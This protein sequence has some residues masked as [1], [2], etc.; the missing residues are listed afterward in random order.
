MLKL[1]NDPGDEREDGRLQN[2][3]DAEN[4]VGKRR[5]QLKLRF[6]DD[7]IEPTRPAENGTT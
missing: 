2:L 3:K 7:Q 5:R 6:Y 4:V 1:E